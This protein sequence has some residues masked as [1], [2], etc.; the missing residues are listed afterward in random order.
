MKKIYLFI[1]ITVGFVSIINFR[2][3]AGKFEGADNCGNPGL[4]FL[5]CNNLNIGYNGFAPSISGYHRGGSFFCV[6]AQTGLSIATFA[7]DMKNTTMKTGITG[8][9]ICVYNSDQVIGGQVELNFVQTGTKI[10]ASDVQNIAGLTTLS[11]ADIKYNFSN[12]I[13]P[14]LVKAYFGSKVRFFLEGGPYLSMLIGAREKG[15]DHMTTTSGLTVI[16]DTTI[17]VNADVKKDFNSFDYGFA[18][19][20]GLLFP[21]YKNRGSHSPFILFTVRYYY[22]LTNILKQDAFHDMKSENSVFEIKAGICIPL[23]K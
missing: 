19:G 1:L 7:G 15:T 9:L 20:S 11:E 13:M 23:S 18:L 2:A 22:G 16:S 17:S 12:I 5:N 6:G 14:M 8:G 4:T 3:I 21:I 10:K